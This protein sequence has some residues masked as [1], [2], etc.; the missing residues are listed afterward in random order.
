MEISDW[1]QKI[2]EIDKEILELLNNRIECVISVAQLKKEKGIPIYSAD[3]EAKI[4]QKLIDEQKNYL[5]EDTIKSVFTKIIN[6][7]KKIMEK[8][9]K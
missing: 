6:E 8:Y 3:R 4:F 7:S 1:R 2:D 5:E 9:Y